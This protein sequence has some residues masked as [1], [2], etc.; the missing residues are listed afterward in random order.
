MRT[1]SR[2][3]LLAMLLSA[4]TSALLAAASAASKP[5]EERGI[6]PGPTP[7]VMQV[8]RQGETIGFTNSAISLCWR[9]T[10]QGLYPDCLRDEQRGQSLSLGREVFQIILADGR[11]Y[12]A[13]ELLP[14]GKPR[15]K[16]V[17]PE[18]KAARLA[19][20]IRASRIELPLRSKDR[21][22]GVVWRAVAQDDANYVRQELEITPREDCLIAEIV[23]LAQSIP[24]ARTVGRVD[25]SPVVASNFFFGCEDPLASNTV[26]E[27]A[28]DLVSCRLPRKAPLNRGET[29]AV[30]CFPKARCAERFFITWNA[31]GPILTAPICITIP[32]T[33]FAPPR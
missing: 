18:P 29:L 5:S 26:N 21:A 32:G 16:T 10:A 31:S 3:V 15:V 23:W 1:K 33:T 30:R 14:E 17:L 4:I 20:R 12:A 22:L 6:Y 11:S 28:A 25:G 9:V 13:S 7:G 8:T 19:A 2:K 24:G 27:A